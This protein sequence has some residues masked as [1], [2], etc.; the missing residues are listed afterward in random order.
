[1]AVINK[2]TNSKSP[3]IIRQD[4]TTATERHCRTRKHSKL[5]QDIKQ[6]STLRILGNTHPVPKIRHGTQRREEGHE[7]ERQD[8][9]REIHKMNKW[10]QRARCVWGSEPG[11]ASPCWAWLYGRNKA[12]GN[13]NACAASAVTEA[14]AEIQSQCEQQSFRDREYIQKR[15]MF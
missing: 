15:N 11:G 1:M 4:I 6:N 14:Q 13:F 9:T 7:E 8:K 12:A 3:R 2:V 10:I 5:T